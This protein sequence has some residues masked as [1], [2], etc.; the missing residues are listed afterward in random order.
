MDGYWQSE[1]YFIENRD[2]ILN[3]LRPNIKINDIPKHIDFGNVVLLLNQ[4][5]FKNRL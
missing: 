1:K 5:Y 2:I 4:L 3:E